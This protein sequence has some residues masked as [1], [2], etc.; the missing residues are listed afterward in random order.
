M[1]VVV[2]TNVVV[3]AIFKDRTPE[4]VLTHIL[5]SPEMTWVASQPILDE[6]KAVLA[7]PKFSLPQTLLNEWFSVFDNHIT[8]VEP[9]IE[10]QLPRDP[11]DA[12]F[13]SCALSAGANFIITGDRDFTEARRIET[14]SVISV[15]LYA[16][17]FLDQ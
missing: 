5:S 12:K 13:L 16:R 7:R 15:A 3:S 1:K 4:A 8:I 14:T 6:Y 2:D 10:L 11:T 17:L 9:D